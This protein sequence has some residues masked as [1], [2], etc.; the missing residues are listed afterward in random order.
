MTG[1][2]S[3]LVEPMAVGVT[4]RG[5]IESGEVKGNQRRRDISEAGIKDSEIGS[6]PI[7]ATTFSDCP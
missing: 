2:S 4:A 5:E 7:T 6:H 3:N 1:R